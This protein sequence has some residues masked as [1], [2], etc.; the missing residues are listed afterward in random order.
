MKQERDEK[1]EE[2]MLYF[3]R[4]FNTEFVS[5]EIIREHFQEKY[6]EMEIRRALLYLVSIHQFSLSVKLDVRHNYQLTEV[7]KESETKLHIKYTED[8]I[9]K[10]NEKYK[11]ELAEIYDYVPKY[12]EDQV[13]KEIEEQFGS[14]P[15]SL[16]YLDQ[17]QFIVRVDTEKRILGF[18]IN[19]KFNNIR[20]GLFLDLIIGQ[21]S[22]NTDEKQYNIVKN[23][24]MKKE[25][26]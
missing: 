11:K 23:M 12:M 2:E 10:I 26:D 5:P 19:P 20:D 25:N 13:K 8:R 22:I 1:L 4:S 15:N 18:S 3:V 24:E 9:K 6:D 16:I 14:E 21:G 7:E 17:N